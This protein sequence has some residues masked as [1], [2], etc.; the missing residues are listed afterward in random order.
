VVLD[1]N[2][3]ASLDGAHGQA[4]E[5]AAQRYERFIGMPVRLG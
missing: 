2:L 1:T 3:F 4:L 5:A